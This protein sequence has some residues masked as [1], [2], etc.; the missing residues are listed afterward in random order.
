MIFYFAYGSNLH[1]VRLKERVPSAELVGVATHSAHKLSF[2]KKSHDGSSKCNIYNSGSDSDLIY[3]AI[4]KLKPE[5]KAVLD[6][7]EGKGKGY[8]DHSIVL[9]HNGAE[10]SCFTY[11][12]Q[13][14]HIV[15]NLKP[16]HWYKK[17]VLL[18]AQ[19]LDFPENYISLITAIDSMR[20]P[21]STRE[22]ETQQLIQRMR[23][24]RLKP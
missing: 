21:D 24:Y 6:R 3:G 16:Y 14:S 2:D 5:H 15:D 7:F 23:N 9:N 4:Y 20:D 18:G 22:K 8:I 10:V 17:L 19:Y 12:A 1:P 13:Q 11:L